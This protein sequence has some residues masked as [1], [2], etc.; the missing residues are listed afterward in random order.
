[1]FKAKNRETHEIVALKRVRL[2]DDDE[3]GL[4]TE[5]GPGEGVEGLGWVG[6]DCCPPGPLT[7]AGCAEFCPPGDLPT[8]GAEAQEHR[9]VCGRR[10]LLAGVAAWGR[11]GLTLDVCQADLHG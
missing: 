8:Q 7:Y 3:V 5:I 4:G 2:D 1:M 6:S 10:V 9:Q 11:R